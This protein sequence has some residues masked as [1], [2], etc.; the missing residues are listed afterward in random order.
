MLIDFDFFYA[1]RN[2]LTISNDLV[3]NKQVFSMALTTSRP[4]ATVRLQVCF[5][6]TVAAQMAKVLLVTRSLTTKTANDGISALGEKL[7][8]SDERSMSAFPSTADLPQRNGHVSF[9][10]KD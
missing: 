3:E 2:S 8:P 6:N 1:T 4:C 10:P 7:T 9:V 5:R